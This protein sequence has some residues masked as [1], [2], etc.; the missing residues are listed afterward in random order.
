[1]S[2]NIM[3]SHVKTNEQDL[4][5]TKEIRHT[6]QKQMD[7]KIIFKGIPIAIPTPLK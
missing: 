7:V 4:N 6:Q 5:A 1:M 2:H 3:C